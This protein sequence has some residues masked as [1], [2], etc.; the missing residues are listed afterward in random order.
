MNLPI[1]DLWDGDVDLT[2]LPPSAKL[3]YVLL[4]LDGPLTRQEL[5][6]GGHLPRSTVSHAVRRLLEADL[7]T[8]HCDPTDPRATLLTTDT[9]NE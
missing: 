4:A 1:D 6:E 8:E 9:P 7:V 3:C 2:E 5:A